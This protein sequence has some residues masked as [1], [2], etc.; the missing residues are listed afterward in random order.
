M[1]ADEIPDLMFNDVQI[2][3]L[4]AFQ[5]GKGKLKFVYEVPD[6][7]DTEECYVCEMTLQELLEEINDCHSDEWI[8]Y[9]ETDWLEGMFEW[10]NYRLAFISSSVD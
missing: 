3:K 7:R 2:M 9:D 8:P 4:I 1:K 6:A 10:T 5:N